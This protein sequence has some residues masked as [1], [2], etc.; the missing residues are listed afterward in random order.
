VVDNLVTT[1]VAVPG[2]LPKV[3]MRAAEID[4]RGGGADCGMWG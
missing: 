3:G 4:R 1:Q 2:T